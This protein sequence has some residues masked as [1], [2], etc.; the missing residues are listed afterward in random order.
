MVAFRVRSEKERKKGD[1]K[2]GLGVAMAHKLG[3]VVFIYD[4]H[5]C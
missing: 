5:S 4:A 2:H 3:L 1:G